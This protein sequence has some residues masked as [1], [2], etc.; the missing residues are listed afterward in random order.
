VAAPTV[1]KEAVSIDPAVEADPR[2]WT[3]RLRTGHVVILRASGSRAFR[4]A[5]LIASV[6]AVVDLAVIGSAVEADL[7]A[8]TASVAAGDSGAV[9]LV[10]LAE[11]E[12]G[13]GVD[14]DN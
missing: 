1:Q 7:A 13:L 12:A 8:A 14:D 4:A 9:A 3:A 10:A 5:A 11:A 6:A 2:I